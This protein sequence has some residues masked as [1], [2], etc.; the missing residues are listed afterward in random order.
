[1]N[2][3]LQIALKAIF[4]VWF[5]IAMVLQYN[6]GLADNGDFTRS[7]RSISQGPVGIDPNWPAAGSEDWTRRFNNYWLPYWKLD[8]NVERPQTSAIFLWLPGAVL[9]YLVYS[10]AVLFMPFLALPSKLI[11]LGILLLIFKWTGL[12]S[13][14]TTI[15]LFSVGVPLILIFTNT[16]HMAYFNS[17]YLESASFIFLFFFIISILL[18]KHDPSAAYLLCNLVAIMLLATARPANLYWPILA[19]PFVL[20]VWSIKKNIPVFKLALASLIL[21]V[22]LT[23]MSAFVTVAG[24][25][26]A[27]PY[28]SLFVGVLKFSSDPQAHLQ[29]LGMEDAAPCVL[30]T[31]FT[32]IG[33]TCL[34]Q[35]QDQISYRNTGLVILR[36]PLVL[37]RALGFVLDNMQDLSVDYLGKYSI[38]DPRSKTSPRIVI[39]G[40]QQRFWSQTTEPGWLNLWAAVKFRLFPTGYALAFTLICFLFWF[41]WNLKGNDIK[42][43]L[44]L[45][46]LMS[47]VACIADMI[48]AILGDGIVELVRHLFLSNLLFDI[49]L[50]A[51]FSSVLLTIIELVRKKRSGLSIQKTIVV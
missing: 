38:D 6:V 7:I 14:Y 27:N 32:P 18:L 51:F 25:N 26:Q 44:A 8:W 35:F 47:T 5:V 45:I 15:L 1:M 11:L 31:A 28:N 17:F 12:N 3:R 36:E 34:T 16:E 19:V 24:S 30:S 23:F 41:L 37:F 29:E 33:V 39:S 2:S 49:A 43:D 40:E 13:R 4:I 50:I 10:R 22:L 48:I 20:Y 21:I 42:Q 9:N 46:G